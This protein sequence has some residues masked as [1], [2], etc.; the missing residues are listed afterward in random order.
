[1]FKFTIGRK[2]YMVI[3]LSFVG[4]LGVMLFTMRDLQVSLEN[5]KTSELKHLT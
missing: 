4:F 2:I 1:M 5:Q 3:G